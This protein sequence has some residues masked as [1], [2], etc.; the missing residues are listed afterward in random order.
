MRLRTIFAICVVCSVMI[1]ISGAEAVI[2]PKSAEIVPADTFVLVNI[3]D[4]NQ[5]KAKFEKSSLYKMYKDPAMAAFFEGFTNKLTER[6]TKGDD[7]IIGIKDILDANGLPEGRIVIALVFGEKAGLEQA[8]SFLAIVQWGSSA[9][10]AKEKLDRMTAK[11]IEKGAHRAIEEYRDVNVVTLTTEVSP[12]ETLSSREDDNMPARTAKPSPQRDVFCFIDDC[13]IVGNDSEAVKFIVAHI[14][15]AIGTTLAA[16]TDYVSVMDA[17]GPY[18]DIDIYV[19]LRQLLRRIAAEDKTGQGGN[20]LSNLGL[21]NAAGLGFSI[22]LNPDGTGSIRGKSFLKTTG[23]RKGILKML[24]TRMG[25]IRPPKF[26]PASAYS[27]SF[28]NID[29]KRAFD[30][31][32]SIKYSFDP[33]EAMAMQRPLVEAG[34]EGEPAVSL[35][36]D[37]IEYLGSEIVFAQNMNKPFDAGQ[38]P[39]ETLIAAA[40]SDRSALEKSLSIVHRKLIAPLNPEPTRELLGHTIYTMGPI[41]VP[42]LGGAVPMQQPGAQLGSPGPRLAFT[43][44]DTHLILG[45]EPAVERAIRTLKGED[46]QSIGS[47]NWFN[48][49]KSAV[50]SVV[51]MAGFEN[52]VASGELLWWMLKESAK[53]RRA[54]MGMGPAAA[55]L[56]GPDFWQM[57]NFNLLPEFDSVRKYFGYSAFYGVSRPDGFLFEFKYINPRK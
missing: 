47:T 51:G 9:A 7:S 26:V 5:L 43:I 36:K 50:P 29:V 33:A 14:K 2:L 56:A 40:I 45:H 12:R 21:D 27:I 22:G 4:V 42:I 25:P 11:F 49:V 37:I 52:T 44:T 24:E 34:A 19:N 46:N 41:G 57:G 54:S 20:T 15:G 30:E 28:L 6:M 31:Y 38:M 16:D 35:R 18:H 3:S 48:D 23:S 10:K 8:P 39:T 55:V 53:S 17:T 32:M 13:L 1:M